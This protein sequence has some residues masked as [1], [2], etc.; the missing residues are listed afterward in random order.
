FLLSDLF[1]VSTSTVSSIFTTWMFYLFAIF[2]D[3][4]VWPSR[5]CIKKHMPPSFK[6]SFPRTRC[7]I[8]CT[9][10]FIQRPRD[11][12]N[13]AKTYSS[14]KSHN[15]YKFLI[16]ITPTGAISFVSDVWGGNTSDRYITQ[17]S[18]FLDMISP[19]DEIMADRGFTIRDLLT[20]RHAHLNIP[21]F[22]RKCHWGKGK[23]LNAS[24][25]R[26]TR[27]IANLR[28]HVERAIQRMK[29]FKLLSQVIPWRM[30][31]VVSCAT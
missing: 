28:I 2:K 11:P 8:D 29:K 20:E 19:G 4:I 27:H 30:K 26:K 16:A 17:N 12:S 3:T 22:T 25:I 6:K 9:E 24:E 5:E 18:G 7:I 15:T 1:G 21:P 31:S 13:Q 10:I 23:R 14:Y